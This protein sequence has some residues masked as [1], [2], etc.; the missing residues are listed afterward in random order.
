MQTIVTKSMRSRLYQQHRPVFSRDYNIS[1]AQLL[2]NL[3]AE[4]RDLVGAEYAQIATALRLYNLQ[5]SCEILRTFTSGGGLNP[6]LSKPTLLHIL[7]RIGELYLA[8]RQNPGEPDLTTNIPILINQSYPAAMTSKITSLLND[9]ET[10]FYRWKR[11]ATRK[12]SRCRFRAFTD[13]I[14]Q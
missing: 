2:I 13:S 12:S 14:K 3:C 4:K 10:F 1:R 5:S 8:T 11:C 9:I 7:S 6:V